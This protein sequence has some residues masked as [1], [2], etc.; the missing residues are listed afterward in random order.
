MFTDVR[1]HKARALVK[2]QDVT[3]LGQPGLGR[4]GTPGG[5]PHRA[6]AGPASA[7]RMAGGR[8]SCACCRG[9]RHRD[10]GAGSPDFLVLGLCGSSVSCFH[11]LLIERGIIRIRN[12]RAQTANLEKQVRATRFHGGISSFPFSPAGHFLHIVRTQELNMHAISHEGLPTKPPVGIHCIKD[13][14]MERMGASN[15][16]EHPVAPIEVGKVGVVWK[17]DKISQPVRIGSYVDL[18]T[19]FRIV[20]VVVNPLDKNVAGALFVPGEMFLIFGK[21]MIVVVDH[22][23]VL[24]HHSQ[25]A[26]RTLTDTPMRSLWA[27]VATVRRKRHIGVNDNRGYGRPAF[28]R[29]EAAMVI[30]ATSSISSPKKC[31][32]QFLM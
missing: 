13:R 5:R 24:V 25:K 28:R 8:R 20:P 22:E 15:S 1:Y 16:Y 11:W 19:P 21:D 30:L 9:L 2:R 6:G 17:L 10:R 26:L 18:V 14:R 12:R 4:R 3:I 32:G 23:L 31:L 29:S 7:V 27:H